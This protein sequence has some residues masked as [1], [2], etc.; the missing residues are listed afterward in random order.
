MVEIER[1]HLE[2]V[3]NETHWVIEGPKGAASILDLN[4]NTLRSRIKKLGLQRP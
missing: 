1:H 3:L 4:P 2:Q